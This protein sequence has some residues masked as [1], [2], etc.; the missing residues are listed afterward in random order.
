MISTI[1][2]WIGDLFESTLR[3]NVKVMDTSCISPNVTRIRFK[4]DIS[5]MNFQP[6]YANVIRVTETEYRNY[7]VAFHDKEKGV[8]D[9]IFHIHGNG[10]GS[11]YINALKK[12]DELYISHPRGRQYY[13]PAVKQQFV[14]GDETGL[15]VALSLMPYFKKNN[16]T[17]QYCFELD[18]AN[19]NAPGI[20]G[21]EN[22]TVFPKDG[23][24][25]Q[26]KW[27]HDLPLFRDPDWKTGNFILVGN[28]K[29][30]LA[31]KKVLKDNMSGKIITQGYW[32]EGKKGL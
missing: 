10:V 6:G 12:G 25:W 9:I 18:G 32:L 26:E 7:T 30:V 23:S 4:G 27:I 28:V 31:F 24:F 11:K 20:L 13:D 15:G 29:S 16:H 21:L 19:K 22:Y 2:K 5:K 1:P 14:F 8:F 17:F 3:P